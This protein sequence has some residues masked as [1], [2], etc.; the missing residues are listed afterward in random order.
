MFL[1]NDTFD[2]LCFFNSLK[3]VEAISIMD[4]IFCLIKLAS[5][6]INKKRK[7][8]EGKGYIIQLEM[9]YILC[10]YGVSHCRQHCYVSLLY[11]MGKLNRGERGK[12]S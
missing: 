7:H 8:C 6:R 10:F 5:G 11:S 4:I 3:L 9:P 2:E 12:K 1:A